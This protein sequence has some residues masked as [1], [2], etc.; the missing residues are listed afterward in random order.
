[1]KEK[2]NIKATLQLVNELN[3]MMTGYFENTAIKPEF[4]LIKFFSNKYHN[5]SKKLRIHLDNLSNSKQFVNSRKLIAKLINKNTLTDEEYNSLQIK[6]SLDLLNF[7]ENK[8]FPDIFQRKKIKLREV[9]EWEHKIKDIETKNKLIKI[10]EIFENNSLVKEVI[11]CGSFASNDYIPKWSDV[12][13]TLILSKKSTNY[14]PENFKKLRILFLKAEKL[15]YL[16][17]PLQHHTFFILNEISF[18][19]YSESYFFP[20]SMIE[21]GI[22]LLN[23]I[24]E[25]SFKY[26]NFP[27]VSL[28]KLENKIKYFTNVENVLKIESNP[29]LLKDLVSHVL[30][31]PFSYLNA[32]G[33]Y[34]YKKDSFSIA[35][36]LSESKYW[37]D[38]SGWEKIRKEWDTKMYIPKFI[39]SI[40]LRQ[41]YFKLFIKIF[42][43]KNEL[44]S[45]SYLLNKTNLLL[46]DLGNDVGI[47]KNEK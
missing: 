42:N 6:I 43:K 21:N 26:S 7:Y 14:T 3:L 27:D 9:I 37:G 28:R 38:Y 40:E 46:N 16:I 23:R 10:G 41:I 13:I 45:L 11:L 15:L 47:L 39:N 20:I 34:C 19:N 36:K 25:I 4:R 12:D 30:N 31:I 29:Y 8:K 22:P 32:K 35:R 2:E 33:I 18:N 1:M 44:I 24:N 5:P 17:D